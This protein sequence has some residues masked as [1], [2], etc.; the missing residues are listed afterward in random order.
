MKMKCDIF[1]VEQLHMEDFIISVGQVEEWQMTNDIAAL[2]VIFDRAKRVIVG[3]GVVALVREQRNGQAYRFDE[4]STPEDLEKYKG[5][6]YK[7][8]K[9]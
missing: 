8:L 6:V 5:A 1:V 7:Y 4:F 9:A 2:D 3:G